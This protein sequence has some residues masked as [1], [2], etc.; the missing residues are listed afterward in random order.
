MIATLRRYGMI[1]ALFAAGT[2]GLSG[3]VY[4]LTKPEIDKQAAAQQKT[5][6]AEILPESVYNN[7][8]IAEC[9]LVTDPALGNELPHR[10]YVA[11]KDGTPVAAVLESTAPDGYS[12]NIQLLV[13][14]DF[15]RTVLG[16]RVT[17]HKETPGL[18]DK[19]DT[20]I[21]DWITSLSGKHIESAD[22][23]HW[24]VKKD[25]GDFDQFT[26]ATITPRAVV[27][28]VRATADYM[29]TLPPLLNTLPQCGAE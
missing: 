14:A 15:N 13:A 20:R 29:Q 28:A 23:P 2:T 8:V 22:D 12:G 1:L 19:I 27:N 10:L 6:F 11:R 16:S 21:S 3:F 26:G 17:E 18:G 24:A 25:G 4:T 7:D 9:Y 5:L